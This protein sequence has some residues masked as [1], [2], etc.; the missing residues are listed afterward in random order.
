MSS[1][2]NKLLELT[3]KHARRAGDQYDAS[4]AAYVAA[5]TVDQHRKAA[6]AI[7]D[8]Y[9]PLKSL[10]FLFSDK[11]EQ[12]KNHLAYRKMV[13]HI[14]K[15]IS[16]KM[17]DSNAQETVSDIL[18]KIGADVRSL[19]KSDEG[20]SCCD[21]AKTLKAIKDIR[22][23]VDQEWERHFTQQTAQAAKTAQEMLE[24]DRLQQEEAVQKKA[25]EKDKKEKKQAEKKR[26]AEAELKRL[27]EDRIRQAEAAAKEKQ[28]LEEEER[29]KPKYK[30][31]KPGDRVTIAVPQ[32]LKEM[33]KA[34]GG[35]GI[36]HGSFVTYGIAEALEIPTPKLEKRHRDYDIKVMGLTSDEIQARVKCSPIKALQGQGITCLRSNIL[37]LP[38]DISYS[39]ELTKESKDEKERMVALRECALMSD[40]NLKSFH[41]YLDENTSE[42]VVVDVLNAI[43]DFINGTLKPHTKPN[44]TLEETFV[45]DPTRILRILESSV[46]LG[47]KLQQETLE[48]IIK[49]AP[50]LSKIDGSLLNLK[51][52]RFFDRG[53]GKEKFNLLQKTALIEILFPTIAGSVCHYTRW[54]NQVLESSLAKNIHALDLLYLAMITAHKN[55]DPQLK[56]SQIPHV[57]EHFH[58]YV[59]FKD[60]ASYLSGQALA[61]VTKELENSLVAYKK[62]LISARA[63]FGLFP[64]E[65]SKQVACSLSPSYLSPCLT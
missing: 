2:R 16:K 26:A 28:R 34:L 12:Q 62:E 33:L 35:L 42:V 7:F 15:E 65:N 59:N 21:S 9:G 5:S 61:D 57:F 3:A 40:Q 52:K 64:V 48:A 20:C 46:N 1:G 37:D 44:K 45:E 58:V 27:E 22:A 53:F 8:S 6:Q 47:I 13:V 4:I 10:F 11:L 30:K 63:S 38:V 39:P 18:Q 32:T 17:E 24:S 56:Y 50:A 25:R 51:M 14:V 49:A 19:S 36:L 60:P 54:I 23:Y 31:Y 55:F 41:A 29:R 43:P